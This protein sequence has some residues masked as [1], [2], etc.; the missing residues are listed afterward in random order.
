MQDSVRYR[1]A[2]GAAAKRH[3]WNTVNTRAV[4]RGGNTRAVIPYPRIGKRGGGEE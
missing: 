4:R 2:A 3:N 1:A